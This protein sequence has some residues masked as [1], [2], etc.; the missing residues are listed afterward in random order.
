M[1]T[2]YEILLNP[3]KFR[4]Y[5][6]MEKIVADRKVYDIGVKKYKDKI[7]RGEDIGTLIVVQH[8]TEDMYAVLDGHHRFWAL[9]ELEVTHAPCAIMEDFFGI[10]FHLTKEG[11]Y[12]PPAW[13]TEYFRVPY[14]KFE[15]YIKKFVSSPIKLLDEIW[16]NE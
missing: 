5:I 8:P 14:R 13:F 11:Y 10:A 4:V 6:E 1:A 12:Q 2:A 15:E 3:D 9:K 7:L 16:R